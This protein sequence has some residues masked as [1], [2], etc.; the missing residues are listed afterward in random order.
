MIY[1]LNRCGAI[2]H[3]SGSDS[4][5]ARGSRRCYNGSPES[6]ERRATLASYGEMDFAIDALLKDLENG[7]LGTQA[8][9]EDPWI[10]EADSRSADYHENM[11][12]NM[13]EKYMEALCEWC[14]GMYPG[15]QIIFSMDNAKYHRHEYQSVPSQ[16]VVG[17]ADSVKLSTITCVYQPVDAEARSKQPNSKIAFSVNQVGTGE[18]TRST[19]GTQPQS[20]YN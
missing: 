12:V 13:F 4:L 16:E 11:N 10:W 9:D 15:K 1:H 14:K 20:A 3:Q 18:A 17:A 5:T 7:G 2:T 19:F 6:T 8:P